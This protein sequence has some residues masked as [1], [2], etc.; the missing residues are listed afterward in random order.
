MVFTLENARQY[1]QKASPKV[2]HLDKVYQIR[3]SP[4]DFAWIR[5]AVDEMGTA[6]SV[7]DFIRQ[8]I[9][10]YRKNRLELL[11]ELFKLPVP[12]TGSYLSPKPPTS[13]EILHQIKA[14]MEIA[15]P[16]QL[17]VRAHERAE[18]RKRLSKA[19]NGEA[20][21]TE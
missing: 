11:C 5:K 2:K 13:D 8:A 20:G 14:E 7:A 12:P 16:T 9:E 6:K 15:S 3:M 21:H 18:K 4:A 17:Q 19:V 10:A 1:R